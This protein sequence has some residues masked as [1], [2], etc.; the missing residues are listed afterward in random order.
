M[1]E[2]ESEI[3]KYTYDKYIEYSNNPP[4]ELVLAV[5][6][7]YSNEDGTPTLSY[8]EAKAKVT[9]S[10]IKSYINNEINQKWK[11]YFLSKKSRGSVK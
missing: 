7:E 3:V 5:I 6:E 1:N 11:E 8:D 4:K 9:D 10:A 2:T